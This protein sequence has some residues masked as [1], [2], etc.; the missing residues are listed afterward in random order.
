M[1]DDGAGT[2]SVHSYVPDQVDQ[3]CWTRRGRGDHDP[4]TLKLFDKPRPVMGVIDEEGNIFV[5]PS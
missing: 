3:V 2:A 1:M 5:H 4:G